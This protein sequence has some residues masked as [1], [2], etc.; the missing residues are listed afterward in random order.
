MPSKPRSTLPA[1]TPVPRQRDRLD[2]WTPEVQQA[3]IEALAE[4]GS[5]RAACRRVGRSEGGAYQM[6]RHP[7]GGQFRKAWAAALDIGIQRIE[8]IAMERALYGVEEP[9]YSYGKIVGTRV[10]YN[11]RLLM[12]MLRNRAPRRFAAH[13]NGAFGAPDKAELARLKKEWRREWQLEEDKD[14]QEVLN[15]IDQFIDNMAANR[16]ANMSPRAR[17]AYEKA[18]RIHREDGN[19]WQEQAKDEEEEKGDDAEE[20]PALPAPEGE[21]EKEAERRGP[22]IWT[23]RDGPWG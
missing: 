2:G 17:A 21:T 5:V 6:R 19:Y 23:I 3:F 8:D 14:E 12:F 18:D 4:T 15:S 7:E 20:A 10:R 13:R 16:R 1:F 22:R 9:V 11:D